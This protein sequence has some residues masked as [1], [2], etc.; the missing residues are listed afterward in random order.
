MT[1]SLTEFK[2]QK[3]YITKSGYF[4]AID[5]ESYDKMMNYIVEK[6][7]EAVDILMKHKKVIMLK[8]GL[9]VYLVKVSWGKVII[10]PKGYDLKLW[11]V[12]E[13]IE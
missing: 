8:E 7:M 13:A 1:Y 4:A 6:D 11:T 12:S 5:E 3:I 2:E 9:Q 10:R